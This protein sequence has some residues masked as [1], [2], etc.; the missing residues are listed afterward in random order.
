ML[1]KIYHPFVHG[2]H[3]TRSWLRLTLSLDRISSNFQYSMTARSKELIIKIHGD[4]SKVFHPE[5]ELST[6]N[7]TAG[8]LALPNTPS[9]C[10]LSFRLIQN[11]TTI[12][13]HQTARWL[14]NVQAW[15]LHR[16]R[17]FYHVICSKSSNFLGYWQLTV[18]KTLAKK[19]PNSLLRYLTMH[20]D[21]V[22]FSRTS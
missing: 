22:H 9:L 2:T 18:C 10:C 16:K 7:V 4:N 3:V 8:K 14:Q 17:N 12:W 1:H 11:I 13:S 6:R 5:V 19:N 15:L 21:P 20:L